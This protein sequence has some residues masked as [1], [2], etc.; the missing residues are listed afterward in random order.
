MNAQAARTDES[1]KA[2][3]M[4]SSHRKE[5]AAQQGLVGRVYQVGLVG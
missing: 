3:F 1:E 2:I 4:P 5:L